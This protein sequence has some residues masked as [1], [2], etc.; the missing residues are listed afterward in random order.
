[1]EKIIEVD[2]RE[3]LFKATAS[4][5]RRYRQ[6]FH[7]DFF[8]DMSVLVNSIGKE[9]PLTAEMLE[10]FENIAYLMAKQADDSIPSSPDEWLDDF[11]LMSIYEVLPDIVALWVNSEATVSQSKKKQG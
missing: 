1:M 10:S 8:A 5:P 6:M 7:K 4:T 11:S 3:V 9:T 2:G